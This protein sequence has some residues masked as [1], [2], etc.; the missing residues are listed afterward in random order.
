MRKISIY[1]LVIAMG[2]AACG[3]GEP[4][5]EPFDPTGGWQLVSGTSNGTSITPLASHPVTI[6]FGDGVAGGRSACN[7]YGGNYTLQGT[8]LTIGEV[9]MTEMACEPQE[10]MQ[11]ESQYL[12]ALLLVDA[13]ASD[14]ANLVLTGPDTELEFEPVLPTPTADVTGTVW[15]LDTLID[16]DAA[17]S[18]AGDRA[19]L[20]I[21][22][23]GSFIAGTGCRGATGTYVATATGFDTPNMAMSG[24]CPQELQA[25]DSHVVSVLGD[26]FTAEVEGQ[27]MTLIDPGGLGLV[28]RA[29]S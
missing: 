14:G 3:S 11:L 8:S 10:V 26:G 19:T 27:T 25:Q 24:E 17:S 23:D 5:G 4:T 18:V 12:A 2:L 28:Y 22:T 16:N 6:E 29:D 9:A 7:S 15:V 1:T 13:L 21:F 20:E